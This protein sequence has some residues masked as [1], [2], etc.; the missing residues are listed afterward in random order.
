MGSN[1]QQYRRANM[2][3]HQEENISTEVSIAFENCMGDFGFDHDS[4]EE[5]IGVILC[6]PDHELSKDCFN[7]YFSMIMDWKDYQV[8]ELCNP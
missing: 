6:N 7:E 8:F 4:F 1:K 3:W 5:K 2:E